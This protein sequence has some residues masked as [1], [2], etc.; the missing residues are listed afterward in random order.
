MMCVEE[1]EEE[2]G[3]EYRR[4]PKLITPL[5]EFAPEIRESFVS[6][7]I[8]ESSEAMPKNKFKDSTSHIYSKI[9]IEEQDYASVSTKRNPSSTNNNANI[10]QMSLMEVVST[11]TGCGDS[12][13]TKAQSAH[14]GEE[15]SSVDNINSEDPN[16]IF[17][18]KRNSEIS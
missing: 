12:K 1:E 16:N 4:S 6:N 3:K 7:H 14:N 5:D 8:K 18:V 11:T 9:K 10:N 13:H 17:T 2:D 15:F